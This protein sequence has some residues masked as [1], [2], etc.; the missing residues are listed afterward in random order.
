MRTGPSTLA[1]GIGRQR[2]GEPA[3][4]TDTLT[5]QALASLVPP[6]PRCDAVR[7]RS[8]TVVG[9]QPLSRTAGEGG[10]RSEAGEGFPAPRFRLGPPDSGSPDHSTA[11]M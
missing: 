6:L 7:E 9:F 5:H 8:S 10:E 2:T 3:N 1:Y 4:C 11:P